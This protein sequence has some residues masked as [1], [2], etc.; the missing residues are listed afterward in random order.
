[1]PFRRGIAWLEGAALAT[2]AASSSPAR[3]VRFGVA[4]FIGAVRDASLRARAYGVCTAF[5]LPA[6]C[7]VG[8]MA[9]DQ[10]RVTALDIATDH[11]GTIAVLIVAWV[12]AWS[13]TRHGRFHDQ[14]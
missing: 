7:P 11:A 1:M 14:H 9:G 4:P 8:G 2:L 3:G 10:L 6:G 12:L 5:P 13:R